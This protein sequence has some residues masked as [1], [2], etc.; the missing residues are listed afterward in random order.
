MIDRLLAEAVDGQKRA[1]R[2]AAALAM[3]AAIAGV[4]LLATSGWFLTGAAL[5][6]AAGLGAAGTF[7]YLLPSAAIR[8]LAIVRTLGRYGE[9]LYGHR[10]ALFALARLRPA[11]FHLL[12][13]SAPTLA[14][15]RSGGEVAA[16]L[17]SDVDALESGVVRQVTL[18]AAL[19][20]GAAGVVA[21]LLAGWAAA[22]A[23]VAVLGV[24]YVVGR[25]GAP[26]V[27][28]RW[29]RDHAQALAAFKRDYASYAANPEEIAI[30]GLADQ[31]SEALA[32]HSR[33]IAQT[34][35]ALVRGE[36]LIGG[37]QVLFTSLGVAAILAL[38]D[39]GA[40]LA[41]LAALGAAAA[42]EGWSGLTRIAID[43]Q[44]V[45]EAR[46]RLAGLADLPGRIGGASIPP[47]N[48]IAMTIDGTTH[49]L[50]PGARLRLAGG[51]GTGKSRL[52]ATLAGLRGDAPERPAIGGA[53]AA[54]LGLDRLRETFAYAPQ[55]ARLIAGTVADNLRLARP[56]VTPDAMW[57]AL[58]TA[59]LDDMVRA[60][61]AGLDQWLGDDGA[62]LSGGQRKR[63][64]LARALLAGRP[65]L[66]LDEPSE[67][68]DLT[69]EDELADRLGQWLDQTGTGLILVSHRPGLHRLA[70]RTWT[71]GGADEP[72]G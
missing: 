29:R 47:G 3:L 28:A 42:A 68:L 30:Y 65:W 60:L 21:A 45:D 22:L 56:G 57:T 8:A 23:F 39:S 25:L 19:A 40:A 9:R 35:L 63:L 16:S 71:L 54:D 62:R 14:L 50:P 20:A 12:A 26:A 38:A 61:P 51:S 13:S 70:D 53:V 24:I 31:V 43:R 48:G 5:A 18:P 6:G 44:Q 11:L 15:Q 36:A 59:C 4:A 33:Q 34:R 41:A 1:A 2:I 37:G 49:D 17:G 67:G 72:A 64:S 66:L 32:V 7:N 52:L 69:V 27:L 46:G 10:A 58:R 55:D